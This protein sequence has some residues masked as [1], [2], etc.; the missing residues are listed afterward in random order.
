MHQRPA[1][2]RLRYIVNEISPA[3]NTALEEL[4]QSGDAL[5]TRSVKRRAS[6]ILRYLDRPDV[7]ARF[8]TKLLPIKQI[9]VPALQ[10]RPC[11]WGELENSRLG[12]VARSVRNRVI[13]LRWWPVDF[14]LRDTVPPLRA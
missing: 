2:V 7:L 14:V 5:C 9:S 11:C 4:Y 10:W 6:A 8:T 1:Q 3:A 13:C 12:S